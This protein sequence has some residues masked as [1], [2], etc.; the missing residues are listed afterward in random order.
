VRPQIR[1]FFST[2]R[3]VAE[4]GGIGKVRS[5]Y[6]E[7][8]SKE[9]PDYIAKYI[10]EKKPELGKATRPRISWERKN[11]GRSNQVGRPR[12]EKKTAKEFDVGHRFLFGENTKK[13]V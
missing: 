10:W 7:E 13:L 8:G 6:H 12:W 2:N 9:K 11:S 3:R 4:R 1:R 5:G